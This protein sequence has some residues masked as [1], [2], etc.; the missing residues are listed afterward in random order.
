MAKKNATFVATVTVSAPSIDLV[1]GAL[2]KEEEGAYLL[3]VKKPRSSKYFI[4]A[5]PKSQIVSASFWTDDDTDMAL[6]RLKPTN[7]TIDELTGTVEFSDGFITVTD[8]EGT[9]LVV[10]SEFA[11]VT[12]AD[13]EEASKKGKKSA[14][15]ATKAKKAKDEEEEDEEDEEESE[16]DEEEE[17]EEDEEESE[18]DEE[19][20]APKK[21]KK[22]AKKATKAKKAKDEDEDDDD[23][24]E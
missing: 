7:L 13:E 9:V 6:L 10:A 8:E 16:E 19:E 24:D 18:E 11:T 5:V 15:K 23:W 1:E 14:K 12:A 21:G 2:V 17:D 22:S 4:Q 3:R 20:E